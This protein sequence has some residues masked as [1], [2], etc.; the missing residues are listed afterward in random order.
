M[1]LFYFVLIQLIAKHGRKKNYCS[2]CK[3]EY[4]DYLEVLSHLISI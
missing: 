2:V 3:A 4:E 1:T